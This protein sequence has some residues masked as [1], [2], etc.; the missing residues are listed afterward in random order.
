M[1][2]SSKIKFPFQYKE[3][4]FGRIVDPVI[5]LPVLTPNGW[6]KFDFLLDSGADTTTLPFYFTKLIKAEL[7][8]DKKTIVDGVEGRGV[9]GH[10]GKIWIKFG[11]NVLTIRCY[12]IQSDIIPLLGRL[13]VWD[14]FSIIFDNLKQE[15][16]F[17]TIKK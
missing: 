17:E 7:S 6:E 9:A 13:D 1:S 14:K 15:V 8:P 5:P 3:I 16:I 4:D 10:A 12:F 11:Q 2:T